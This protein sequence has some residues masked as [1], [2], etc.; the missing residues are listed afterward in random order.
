MAKS[1]RTNNNRSSSNVNAVVPAIASQVSLGPAMN[2][3]L[4]VAAASSS[5][6]GE[7]ICREIIERI[8]GD[9]CVV[10]VNRVLDNLARPYAVQ[11]LCNELLDCIT[12]TFIARDTGAIRP[13]G[14]VHN[15]ERDAPRR[16]VIDPDARSTMESVYR[17][18]TPSILAGSLS[19]SASMGRP[20]NRSFSAGKVPPLAGT[21]SQRG[22]GQ[23]DS[24]RHSASL[25]VSASRSALGRSPQ[26]SMSLAPAA[27]MSIASKGGSKNGARGN[28]QGAEGGV[29]DAPPPYAKYLPSPTTVD[30]E[31]IDFAMARYAE[32]CRKEAIA[33]RNANLTKQLQGLPPNAM[34]GAP[35]SP[36]ASS[37]PQGA[38]TPIN[39]RGS[40]TSKPAGDVSPTA[41]SARAPSSP[42]ASRVAVMAPTYKSASADVIIDGVAG[43]VIKVTK[44]GS[45]RDG[46][47]L[48]GGARSPDEKAE[49]SVRA[50]GIYS[51]SSGV[52]ANGVAYS[53][54][55]KAKR[56][57]R[58]PQGKDRR[59][60]TDTEGENPHSEEGGKPPGGGAGRAVT[61]SPIDGTS[62]RRAK[63]GPKGADRGARYDAFFVPDPA[64]NPNR[65]TVT[66]STVKGVSV[67]GD[68]SAIRRGPP[69]VLSGPSTPQGT[70]RRPP[71]LNGASA[72]STAALQA[73]YPGGSKS[74]PSAVQDGAG[75]Q[76]LGA[77]L[78]QGW[79]GGTARAAVMEARRMAR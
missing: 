69:P 20:R 52:S 25:V 68:P 4:A 55:D 42:T 48:G 8:V 12:A 28:P 23:L 62:A 1:P 38:T 46:G 67:S 56:R 33:D 10:A 72:S 7:I 30:Q 5:G 77:V 79:G 50:A 32:D 45:L 21:S 51:Q 17:A 44:I 9:A 14:W 36:S 43:R 57:R 75:T 41:A 34:W 31:E 11:S 19:A 76:G 18:H 58:A 40:D 64:D 24:S 37:P 47:G 60:S 35:P 15:E 26:A 63:S 70:P 29:R 6:D 66:L 59:G 74:A 13:S 16:T 61:L 65:M 49:S 22:G 73:T 78:P 53:V 71:Q 27:S 3:A 54:G 2:P 39:K